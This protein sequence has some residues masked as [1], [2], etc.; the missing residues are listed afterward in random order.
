MY[1]IEGLINNVP[2]CLFEGIGKSVPFVSFLDF[3][4]YTCTCI[5]SDFKT[6]NFN[7]MA[8]VGCSG[9]NDPL[10]QYFSPHRAVSQREGERK[11]KRYM[12][13]K[14]SKQPPFAPIASAIG[15]FPTIIQISKTPRHGKLTQ[16]L[17]T[18]RPPPIIWH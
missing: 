4:T 18:T 16:H 5:L 10:R 11:E 15:P 17:R 14:M 7:Y 3:A 2:F 12:R 1:P 9:F 8:L 6:R 13:E